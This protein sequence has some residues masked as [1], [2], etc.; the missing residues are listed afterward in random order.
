[1]TADRPLMKPRLAAALVFL[2]ALAVYVPTLAPGPVDNGDSGEFLGCAAGWGVPHPGG[3]PTYMLLAGACWRLPLPF[4]PPLR[5]ALL[6][7]LAA[8]GAAALLVLLLL[9]TGVPVAGALLL[10]LA[11]VL[12][13][14]VWSQAVMAEVYTLHLLFFLALLWSCVRL[15][16]QPTPRGWL[17]TGLLAGFGLGNHLTLLF[18]LALPLWLL[19]R[20]RHQ[21][22]TRP[23]RAAG[24][25]AGGLLLGLLVFLYLPLAAARQPYLNWGDPSTATRFI[26][27]V[28]LA[29]FRGDAWQWAR[30]PLKMTV[31][32]E[33]LLG[34]LGIPALVLAGLG[35]AAAWRDPVRR[36]LLIALAVAAG[37]VVLAFGQ[38]RA[39]VLIASLPVHLIPAV[40]AAALLAGW[41]WSALRAPRLKQIMFWSLA[42]WFMLQLPDAWRTA[43][44]SDNLILSKLAQRLLLACPERGVLLVE[45]D[46]ITFPL[47]YAQATGQR[48]DVLVVNGTLL[49]FAWY[50]EQLAR[51]AGLP[52]ENDPRAMLAALMAPAPAVYAYPEPAEY[53]KLTAV[54]DKGLFAVI[55]PDADARSEAER[56]ITSLATIG[57]GEFALP[58]LTEME[59]RVRDDYAAALNNLAVSWAR[60]GDP[61]RGLACLAQ[62]LALKPDDPE[63]AGNAALMR[64]AADAH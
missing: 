14:L 27:H 13:P 3:Y 53:L 34:A 43:T 62:A 38:G 4:S 36:A 50:R 9:H 37:M 60:A 59:E 61:R 6:S 8:A 39:E 22:A 28:T 15:M 11:A 57:A 19:W 24:W 12:N 32:S 63:L 40:A 21:P 44:R 54:A 10:A 25:F 52:A 46:D 1:M 16:Q 33:T 56:I 64:R 29:Q 18:L 35:I 23:G 58:Q 51:R 2:V 42:L 55:R 48:P 49:N 17:L 31:L 5:V 45:Q 7:A 26:D 47:W 30:L 20:Q 41:G